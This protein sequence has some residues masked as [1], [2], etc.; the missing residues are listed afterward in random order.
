MDQK[1]IST[2]KKHLTVKGG[3]IFTTSLD[4]ANFFDKK[5]KNVLQSIANLECSA[6]F[7]EL[8]FQPSEYKD[9]TGRML[10]MVEMTRDGFT[11]LAFG[12]TGA[13]AVRWREAYI[14]AFNQ[15]EA[16]VM[17]G[18][19]ADLHQAMLDTPVI[20]NL[21]SVMSDLMVKV[22]KLVAQGDLMPTVGQEK[23]MY[24]FSTDHIRRF[25][26]QRCAVDCNALFEKYVLYRQYEAW[27]GGN[28]EV[29]YDYNNFFKALYQTGIPVRKTERTDRSRG[30]ILRM[31]RGI[32]V[33]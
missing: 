17:T 24:T 23:P 5:H 4:V 7:A 11:M 18:N 9:P 13:P 31:V 16:A 32:R 21:I 3:R 20:Q 1:Q 25:I 28:G 30:T 22:G 29:P 6:E 8:N 10:P 26:D 27:C 19:R 33:L 14:A 12:F 15:M 2:I